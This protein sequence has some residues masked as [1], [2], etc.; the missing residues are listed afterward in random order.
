MTAEAMTLADRPAARVRV[1]IGPVS[2]QVRVP[3]G[4]GTELWITHR[5]LSSNQ[6][7]V[8]ERILNSMTFTTLSP[9]SSQAP[10]TVRDVFPLAS[11]NT[12]VYDVA[13]DYT[14]ES[15]RLVHWTGVVTEMIAE[16]RQHDA[17]WIYLVETQGRPVFERSGPVPQD[18]EEHFLV[19][20]DRLYRLPAPLDSDALIAANGQGYEWN[21]VLAWPI[22]VG[23][24]WGDPK[25]VAQNN[26]W[27]VWRVEAR[28]SVETTAGSFA[29]C[30]QLLLLTNPDDT[31]AWFCP[32]IGF[33]RHEYHH[34][35]SRYDEVW[36]LRELHVRG[37]QPR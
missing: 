29:D 15:K 11:G 18:R 5:P 37:D 24:R 33:A 9:Q 8:F 21:Q 32:G 35:G 26:G 22:E 28:G 34:H 27:Y 30:Y 25:I 2:E 4:D 36:T 20:P 23:Q 17:V 12:W 7:S 14:D 16:A 6:T 13:L 3:L 10:S 31:S 1:N 19:F